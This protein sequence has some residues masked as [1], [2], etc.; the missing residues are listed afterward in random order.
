VL[1]HRIDMAVPFGFVG[2]VRDRRRAWRY[3]HHRFR[4]TIRYGFIDRLR[5]VELLPV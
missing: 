5:I 3:D 4:V 2:V 1:S